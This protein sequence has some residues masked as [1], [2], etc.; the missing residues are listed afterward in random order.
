MVYRR[1]V[2]AM[3]LF[4]LFSLIMFNF[5]SPD[6][7]PLDTDDPTIVVNPTIVEIFE[8]DDYDVMA[9]VS[10]V[11]EDE[12]V[13]I[14]AD[15][16]DTTVL[17]TGEYTITY[18]V[19]GDDAIAAATRTIIVNE[20]IDTTATY[21]VVYRTES[22]AGTYSV[23]RTD[24][25]SGEVGAT[26]TA[27]TLT[28]TGFSFNPGTSTTTGVIDEDD[29]LTLTMDYTRNDYDV[30]F[31]V[32]GE[33]DVVQNYLFGATVSAIANPTRVGHSFSGWGTVPATMP[34][35][36]LLITGS[37]T[38][39]IY[40]ALFYIN[41]QLY[42]TV[43]TAYGA[44][45]A[46]P[47]YTAAQGYTFS[48]WSDVGIKDVGDETFTATLTANTDTEYTVI[49]MIEN[50]DDSEYSEHSRETKTGTTG[51]TGTATEIEIPGFTF[52]ETSTM[53]GTIAGNGS[54]TLTAYYE[55]NEYTITFDSD[56]GSAVDPITQNYG[57]V[58]TAPADPTKEGYT[59]E[60]WDKAIPLTMPAEDTT[61]TANWSE[62]LV[63][64]IDYNLNGGTA[65]NPLTY[66]VET[67]SFTLENP[68]KAGYDFVGWSGTGLEGTDNLIVTIAEG[69]TGNRSY[70]ANWSEALVYEIDYN[71][72]GG[73]ATNPL[74]Y[75]VETE[76]FTL[77]NPTKTGYT[78]TGWSG[79]DLT[80]NDN[81]S[82]TIA[83]GSTGARSYTANWSAINNIEVTFDPQGGNTSPTSKLVTFDAPY[84]ELPTPTKTG[85]NFVGWY[86]AILGG[87]EITSI[88]TVTTASNH[89]LY[90]RW[91]AKTDIL[92]TFDVNGGAQ[93]PSNMLV[94]Y[95]APYGELPTPT[96]IGYN[97]V[98][99]YTAES[100]G[101]LVTAAT[102]VTTE[103]NHTLYAMWTAKTDI[104]IT[105]DPQ[106]GTPSPA[107]KSVTYDSAYGEL[108]T[109]TKAGYDFVGWYTAPSGGDLVTAATIVTT[110]TNH[111]L[112]AMWTAKTDISVSF[113]TQG[114][115]VS[116]SSI[117]VTFASPYGELPTP[118]ITGY[119]FVGWYTAISG[120]SEVTSTT[121]VTT[122]TDHTLYARW[123]GI[124]YTVTFDANGGNV[125]SFTEK[126]V[127]YGNAYGE[128][129]TITKDGYTFDGWFTAATGGIK[130]NTTTTVTTASNHTLYAQWSYVPYTITF[131]P[132]SDIY[133]QVGD[134][135]AYPEVVV[136]YGPSGKK[137]LTAI[138]Y[139]NNNNVI[140]GLPTDSPL[141]N[142]DIGIYYLVFKAESNNGDIG[143]SD[144]VQV[145]VASATVIPMSIDFMVERTLGDNTFTGIEFKDFTGIKTMRIVDGIIYKFEDLKEIKLVINGNKHIDFRFLDSGLNLIDPPGIVPWPSPNA[146]EQ[147]LT[148]DVPAGTKYFDISFNAWGN[149]EVIDFQVTLK[150]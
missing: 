51:T 3:L 131:E 30:I 116:P 81:M 99:W 95:D 90:A 71:L 144:S 68:T 126:D 53:T 41:G 61:I 32:A 143:Y 80:G 35:A 25:F 63:Y 85:Y 96:R 64:E 119:S 74:T 98:G 106:G 11:P 39:N 73:T 146:G 138:W 10:L 45:I 148:F 46:T 114:G 70:T 34:A 124:E 58:V 9:G 21:S 117:L 75:T 24:L 92:V 118:T 87:S 129:P 33:T 20:I 56:G 59:F 127:T 123:A 82:V 16:T 102:I 31:R 125:P 84:G 5:A 89:T 147:T 37:F 145:T 48:G 141:T 91:T 6:L 79:T 115:S 67:E 2:V 50:L 130:I 55:R 57:T 140:S 19:L 110:E 36:D 60:G 122:A 128:L 78:F 22:L 111:T 43:S 136:D 15:I 69:S 12:E 1:K 72:N 40:N 8:G 94:T 49:H 107:N 103:T 108:P 13:E 29:G 26:V 62:A 88:E 150:D 47:T 17:E 76:S 28:F 105:F 77:E 149:T 86:T 97:F 132:I 121:T 27:P 100:G 42:Q 65:T 109:V 133:K 54:L 44:Q 23:V 137:E 52:D 66:T 112:Y 38:P 18:S 142:G 7:E 135:F 93:S 101:T 83:K 139:D 120:G 14:N 134:T 113:N 4:L 104:I